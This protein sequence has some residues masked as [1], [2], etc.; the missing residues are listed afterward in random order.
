[1]SPAEPLALGPDTS[2][3]NLL[4]LQKDFNCFLD[5]SVAVAFFGSFFSSSLCSAY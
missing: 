1:M 2:E 4:S 5:C 3:A